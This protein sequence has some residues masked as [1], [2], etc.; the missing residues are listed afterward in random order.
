MNAFGNQS[1]TYQMPW[2]RCMNLIDNIQ[3]NPN[4]LLM[5]F[6][7]RKG[8]DVIDANAMDVTTLALDL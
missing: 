2:K 3:T 1:K 7:A 4:I 6:I 8:G 5:E